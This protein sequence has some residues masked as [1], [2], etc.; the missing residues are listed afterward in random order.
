MNFGAL[1]TGWLG[2]QTARLGL[3]LF[4]NKRVYRRIHNV[5][6]PT[7]NGTTQIDHVLISPFGIF[8]IETKNMKGWIFGGKDD[9]Q[10]TQVLFGKKYRFQNPLRQNYRDTKSLA[11]FL[12]LD[13]SLFR[14]VVF[15]IGD[16]Q[17]KSAMP[18]EVMTSGLTSYIKGFTNLCLDEAQV[19]QLIAKLDTVK[20]NPNSTRRD[21]LA[22]LKPR[23][24][25]TTMCPRCGSPLQTKIA[26]KGPGAGQSFLGCSRYPV[27]KFTR[28]LQ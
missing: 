19:T 6:I 16:C 24:E 8:V 14:S 28:N 3:L 1:F 21:H 23:H 13:H 27:C 5:L 10:W 25:S 17:F 4:L 15:F 11:D 18:R 9:S 12:S 22:S 20:A 26:R 7:A 2:E